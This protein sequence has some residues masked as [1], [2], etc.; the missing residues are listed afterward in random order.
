V[1]INPERHF[2][3]DFLTIPDKEAQAL[4]DS[5]GAYVDPP[6]V[7][8]FDL[9]VVLVLRNAFYSQPNRLPPG[10]YRIAVTVYSENASPARATFELAWSGMWRAVEKDMHNECVV[11]VRDAAA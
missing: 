6:E 5:L 4:L 1:D 9:G 10:K 2:Y 8:P 3:C 7:K 11:S